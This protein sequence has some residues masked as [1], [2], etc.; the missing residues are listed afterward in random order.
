MT[1]GG[2]KEL[3]NYYDQEIRKGKILVAAEVHGPDAP[4]RL[5]L[6]ARII[7]AAGADPVPLP[8]G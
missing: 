1:R 5:A 6:A 2:E 4:A 7:A 3:S 8:E